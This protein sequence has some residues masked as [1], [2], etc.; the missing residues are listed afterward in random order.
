MEKAD[1]GVAGVAVEGGAVE[2]AL[3]QGC[4]LAGLEESELLIEG[5]VAEFGPGV[6]AADAAVLENERAWE[7]AADRGRIECGTAEQ[8][9]F[10]VVDG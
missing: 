2:G 10:P 9:V 7:G 4:G 5:G 6:D 1:A 8:Q 3:G